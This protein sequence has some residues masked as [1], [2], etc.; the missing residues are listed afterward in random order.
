MST[1]LPPTSIVVSTSYERSTFMSA[2]TCNRSIRR[3]IAERSI[4]RAPVLL[5]VIT[6]PSIADRS[7]TSASALN[8][9]RQCATREYAFG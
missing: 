2:E 7:N 9:L 4:R 3:L 1:I 5:S 8:P 6:S